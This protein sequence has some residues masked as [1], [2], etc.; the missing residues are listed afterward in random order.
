MAS[1][2]S[3]VRAK[4]ADNPVSLLGEG[5]DWLI[6]D[7]ASR[8]KPDIWQN[9]LS[10]RLIDK[11]GWALLIST[12]KGKGYFF[13]LYRR[14][15]GRDPAHRSWNYPS[16]TNPMLDEKLIESQR[17]LISQRA[18][19]Q[20]YGAEFIEG[21]GAVFRHVREAATCGL[22]DPVRGTCYY[23][24]LDLG[25]NEDYT[26]LVILDGQGQVVA[27]DRFLGF[28]WSIQVA[29]IQAQAARYNN[30]EMHIDSTGVGHPIYETLAKAGCNVRAYPFTATSKA[31]LIDNLAIKLER[32]ELT[33]PRADLCPE[34]IEELEAFEYSTTD[35]GNIR[36]GAPYGYHDDCVIALAL[37]AWSLK[38]GDRT[39]EIGM[40][41][42]VF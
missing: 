10:Q 12:P 1:G 30:V 9:H 39:F 20:E 42:E 14:G 26:V 25:R 36:T 23:G 5:L 28:D 35:Q 21:T 22:Q 41:P 32:R 38:R 40:P 27:L 11:K 7:E 2:T 37:A 16:W 3:E 34:L 4:T 8:L 6:V 15:Q 18:F 17:T 31:A 33:L 13:E 19:Q 24:G 29:R